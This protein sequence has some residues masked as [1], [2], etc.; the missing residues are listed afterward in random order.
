MDIQSKNKK[1]IS[2][3]N[4][5]LLLIL[6]CGPIIQFFVGIITP[7][8]NFELL[9]YIWGFVFLIVYAISFVVKAKNIKIMKVKEKLVITM[10][11]LT[12]VC[13]VCVLISGFVK[14]FAINNLQILLYVFLFISVLLLDKKQSKVFLIVLIA[15]F[16]LSCL[17]GIMDPNGYVIPGFSSNH[18]ASALFFVHANYSQAIAA[19]LIVIVYH[20]MIKEKN[21]I[22]SFM[23]VLFFVIIG[24]HMFLNSSSAGISCVFVILVINI[25]V[26]WIRTKKFPLK[27]FLVFLSYVS[28]AFLI[29]LYPN[30]YN[31]RTGHYNY[32]IEV[33]DVF[34]NIFGT[35]LTKSWFN[36]EYV[37]GSNGWER[38]K[39][40]AN[41]IATVWGNSSMSFGERLINNLFGLGGGTLHTLRPH[42][43]FV[44]GWVDFGL[45]FA[46]SLYSLFIVGIIYI[47]K[48]AGKR[49]YEVLPYIY[50]MIAY[51][52]AT[53]FGS[54]LV[55]HFIYFVAIFALAFN[56]VKE[57]I[58]LEDKRI[59][60][61]ILNEDK[62]N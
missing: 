51:L 54:M 26:D 47:A 49:I 9:F 24:L 36:I 55:Y 16:A 58:T 48:K 59:G 43:M 10:I 50:A 29:E 60:Y 14:H 6:A 41:S 53:M 46:I 62:E 2:N 44:G 11:I 3:I 27:V 23:Y 33:V 21:P 18:V 31:L 56:K 17:L 61:Q 20:M 57:N 19:L 8:S 37:P 34:D 40:L 13:L 25:I 38:D 42:N 32:F 28:F 12:F 35:N 7:D 39:L 45:I 4:Y 52:I 22:L 15:N 30:I 5:Y 1:I